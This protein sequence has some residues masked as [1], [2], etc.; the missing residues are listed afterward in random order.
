MYNYKDYEKKWQDA[1][2][3]SRVAYPEADVNK[4]KYFIIW[5]YLT[6]SGFQHVGHMRGYSY[7]DAIARYKRMKGYNVL[8]PA[9]GHASGNGAVAKAQKVREGNQEIISYYKERGLNEKDLQR[10]STPEGFVS[11]F[12]EKYLEDYKEYGF[13]VDNRRFTV[14]TNQD[15]NKFIEWQFKK[16]NE[17]KLLIQKPYFATACVVHGPVAVDPS[18][19]DLS[20]GGNAEK[21][22]YTILKLKFEK[23]NQFIVVATL[24]P[25]TV[26]GQ[27]NIWL[28]YNIDY[29]KIKVGNEVWI[30]SKEFAEKLKYQMEDV[31][32]IEKI[33]GSDLVGRFVEPPLIKRKIIIL[34][35]KFCDPKIGTGVVTSVPSDAPAD[36]M[37]L[38]DLQK[39]EEE[40]KKYNLDYQKIKNIKLISII[41]SKGYGDY[42]A[43][44]I[45]EKLNIKSQ[46]DIEKLEEAKKEIYKVGFHTGIMLSNC[47]IYSGLKVEVAKEKIK[48]DLISKNQASVFYDLSEEVLCRC[49]SQVVIKKIDDQWFIKYSD[50]DLTTK[51]I[52]H[53]KEMNILPDQ[54]KN[55]LPNILN[56]FDDRACARQGTWLGTKLPFDNSYTI[57]PISDS[58]L[59]PIY[60]LVSLY[61]N[62][63]EL[64]V[65]QLNEEFF[66]YVYLEVG[67][68]DEVVKKTEL[69]KE[70][71]LK[72][73]KD[74][75][76][77][78][79]LDIN[80]GGQEH[81]TVH[82]PTFLMNHVAI[83]PEKYYPQGIFVNWWVVSRSGK[84]SK[85][86][87][88]VGSI[89]KEAEKYSVDAIRLFYA[90]VAS[91]FSNI[92]FEE[93]DLF[94]Y[95]T[96]LE[97][98]F[99]FIEN[100]IA[101]NSLVEKREDKLDLWLESTFNIRLNTIIQA[102]EKIEFKVASDE[103]YF[104]FYNDLVW[105]QRRGG[106]NRKTIKQ[107]L[108]KWVKLFGM[109]TPH[110]AEELNSLL[111][112][113]ELIVTSAFPEVDEVKIDFN[114]IQSEKKID[115]IT[116]EIRN[117]LKMANLE[118]PNK[119][120]LFVC[121]EWKYKFYMEAIAE[122]KNTRNIGQLVPYFI[123]H[124]EEH[125]EDVSKILARLI[126]NPITDEIKT[127]AEDFSFYKE[128][129][130]FL[131]KTFDCDVSIKKG[132]DSIHQKAKIATPG[133]VG[134]L[135]E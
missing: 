71:L 15:Y 59:Y 109:F 46:D 114:L 21:N 118:K 85:S 89:G 97:K 135:V 66:D 33:K 24:R 110:M 113:D 101:D 28:D 95:K 37:G 54:F 69:K 99:G 98:I 34:P 73:R 63:G 77:W 38:Y 43:K 27:T 67:N 52:D 120:T 88:G 17:K 105:Y 57:E 115:D 62:S 50:K 94:I 35:S 102:M 39:S 103:I 100:I 75:D 36:W 51:T 79:P 40:C 104:N 44:E 61:V 131:E 19:M 2:N 107:I 42:P 18:E 81:Q 55:N 49:G 133:H 125:K 84:I 47:G 29:Y 10:I 111:G 30:G 127:Q 26:Y 121:E 31:N 96:R 126:K 106:I 87:G 3:K 32:V 12:S 117:V 6:V 56:W 91:P 83:L 25:E 68:I 86:K 74:V 82:F 53:T 78:Y 11:F 134:I 116:L 92:S 7:A 45:C 16:L 128:I 9:G 112:Y 80:L 41:K 14:T 48:E 20:K 13:I 70:L 76:Y 90:N 65:E 132:E 22:E 8:M 108:H 124:Y 119:I 93:S 122:L 58:T 60:Y 129:E 123:S 23:E 130:G 5:A 64:K 72:I 1:W 4:P